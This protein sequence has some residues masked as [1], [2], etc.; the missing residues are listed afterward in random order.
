M[1]ILSIVST[2]IGNLGDIT[3]RAVDILKSCDFVI[4][5]DTRVTGKLL[6][7]FEIDKKMISLNAFTEKKNLEGLIEK[8]IQAEKVAFVTDA[9][10]PAISDPGTRLVSFVRENNIEV[11]V[12]PGPSALTAALSGSGFDTSSF[13]F[14][15]FLPKKKGRQ[16][17]FQK[18]SE[19]KETVVFYESPHRILKTLEELSEKI[20]ERKIG[21]YKEITKVYEEF[22]EGS[23]KE[24][25]EIFQQN[26]DKVKGEFV[27][28][29]ES[30]KN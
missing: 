10:T 26:P 4:C 30:V 13:C 27:V 3:F 6:S 16:T 24:V 23:P 7:H 2:P 9:G 18:I 29:I 1:S 19:I 8:I 17:I 22:F 11:E 21:V 25:F 15:G 5:E 12:I 20:E 28:I 14:L